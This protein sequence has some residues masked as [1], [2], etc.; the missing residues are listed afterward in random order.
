MRCWLMATALSCAPIATT[1]LGAQATSTGG[2]FAGVVVDTSGRPVRD[3]D[4]SIPD[5]S[6]KSVHSD[7]LGAFVLRDVPLGRYEV[8]FRK[9]GLIA[10]QYAWES[11][12]GGRLDVRVRMRPLPNTLDAVKVYAS[13]ERSMRARSSVA[14]TVT[15]SAGVPLDGVRVDLIGG[16]RATITSDDGTF[17]FRHVPPGPMTLRARL[18][19]FSPATSTF[20]LEQDDSRDVY[21]R[22][23]ALPQTLD[24]VRVTALSGF[25]IP[26]QVALRDYDERLRWRNAGGSARFIGP[27]RLQ[28][29]GGGTIGDLRDFPL[30]KRCMFAGAGMESCDACVLVNGVDGYYR[31]LTTFVVTDLEAVEYYPPTSSAGGETEWTGTVAERMQAVNRNCRGGV[32][33]HPAYFVLWTKGSR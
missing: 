33:Q 20:T 13:E 2:T 27:E 8:W 12:A 6:R 25:S 19:G 26:A 10:V 28:S 18:L 29:I 23:K 11:R 7:S 30:A 22:L 1:T 5:A 31:P 14:G 21:L 4:V 15:D 24:E 3:V 9:V 32:G 16:Q 17:M